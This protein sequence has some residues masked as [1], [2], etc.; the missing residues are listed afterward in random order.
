MPDKVVLGSV[1]RVVRKRIVSFDS[2]CSRYYRNRFTIGEAVIRQGLFNGRTISS[3]LNSVEFLKDS[4]GA[5]W[6][7]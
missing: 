1:S 2:I 4:W 6:N 7:V 5:G 3:S